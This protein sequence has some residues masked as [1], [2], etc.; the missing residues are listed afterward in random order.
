MIKF[1]LPKRSF[2][3]EFQFIVTFLFLLFPFSC[4]IFRV[5][6]SCFFPIA[7]FYKAC[8]TTAWER[9]R[10]FLFHTKPKYFR[11]QK[12]SRFSQFDP[13]SRKFLPGRK[14]NLKNAKVFLAKNQLFS[15]L[16]SVFTYFDRF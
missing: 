8:R 15:L 3:F 14:L 6:V 2:D 16:Y 10:H 5:L 11:G 1:Y 13:F 4:R 12:L 9:M 7:V